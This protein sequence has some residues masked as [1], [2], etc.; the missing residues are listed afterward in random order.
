M[1]MSVSPRALFFYVFIILSHF[2][3]LHKLNCTA[4]KTVRRRGNPRKNTPDIARRKQGEEPSGKG[5][6]WSR[7]AAGLC[8]QD[9]I[10][11]A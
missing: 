11:L 4:D 3:V 7:A 9:D 2:L 6:G 5:T 1:T 10:T 8:P